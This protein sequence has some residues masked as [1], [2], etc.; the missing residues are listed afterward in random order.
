[1][2]GAPDRPRITDI[3]ADYVLGVAPDELEAEVV[4]SCSSLLDLGCGRASPVGAF[5]RKLEHCVG[6]DLFEPYLQESV[7]AGIHSDYRC[8]DV[9]Q[10]GQHFEEDAFDCV[11]ALDL[12]EHLPK[13]AG[14][15]LLQA[16]EKVARK[17][18]IVFTPN[19]FVPQRPYDGNPFQEHLSGWSVDEMRSRGYRVLGIHGW[20]PLRGELGAARGRPR[21]LWELIA[22]WSQPLVLHRPA[23]A[24]HLLCV[25]DLPLQRP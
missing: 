6:V 15:D 22:L 10:I 12:I 21:P 5:S 18:V 19:G 17:K 3:G 1:M 25:K 8:L 2:T 20:K 14:L 7:A 13:E 4:G 11:V 23:Q 9:M 16:M 24:F